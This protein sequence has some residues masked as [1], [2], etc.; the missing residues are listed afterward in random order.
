MNAS[1]LNGVHLLASRC[2]VNYRSLLPERYDVEVEACYKT[3]KQIGE[4]GFGTVV[5]ARDRAVDN[6]TVAIKCVAKKSQSHLAASRQEAELMR[7]L[8]H[9]NICKLF[10]IFETSDYI[11]FV[12]EFCE[13]GELL[14]RILAQK[15]ISEKLSAEIVDQVVHALRYSHGRKVAHRDLKPENVCFCAKDPADGRVKVIDWGL[16]TRFALQPMNGNVGTMLYSAPEVLSETHRLKIGNSGGTYS[17]ACDLWSIGVLAYV[18]LCGRPPFWGPAQTMLKKICSADYPMDVA[19]WVGGRVSDSAKDFVR[20]LLQPDPAKRTTI[21][22]LC[23]NPWLRE[24]A[25]AVHA[26]EARAKA[27]ANVMTNLRQFTNMSLF[28]RICVVAIAHQL[29]HQ[30]LGELERVFRE[31]DT[32]GDGILSVE[33]VRAGFQRILRDRIGDSE[34][35]EELFRELDAD[36]S[37]QIDYTEFC[38]AGLDRRASLQEEALWAGFRCLDRRALSGK[39]TCDDLISVLKDVDTDNT[40]DEQGRQDIAS[41]LLRR[42]DRNSDGSIDFDEFREMMMTDMGAHAA[43]EAVVAISTKAKAALAAVDKAKAAS[44]KFMSVS[45]ASAVEASWDRVRSRSRS[46]RRASE[47]GRGG[48]GL[49]GERFGESVATS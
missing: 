33:E 21:E 26:S 12:M 29:G 44:T 48:D 38:A 4:G 17:C 34:Q 9:P 14:S 3:V 8:D 13:G 10:E 11:F 41:E 18:M 5:V 20:G 30:Q 25:S 28:R 47:N 23:D 42:W 22:A 35:I 7:D 15:Y 37:G 31:L 1:A 46:P 32:S 43:A 49:S 36:G 39:L 6:R 45:A 40:F 19:P 16:G 2:K 24:A 27:A